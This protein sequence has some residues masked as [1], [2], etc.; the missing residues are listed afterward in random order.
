MLS[1]SSYV[2]V[3]VGNEDLLSNRGQSY[4]NFSA[5]FYQYDDESNHNSRHENIILL[6]LLVLMLLISMLIIQFS[7]VFIQ[8]FYFINH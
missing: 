5:L 7:G 1:M 4:L 3:V 6:D 2:D 8:F